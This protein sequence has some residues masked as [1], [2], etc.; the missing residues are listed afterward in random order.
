MSIYN[1]SLRGT[2]TQAECQDVPRCAKCL[3]GGKKGKLT[4]NQQFL[5]PAICHCKSEPMAM[6]GYAWLCM[7]YPASRFFW[8]WQA[9]QNSPGIRGFRAVISGFFAI[10]KPANWRHVED[11]TQPQNR[12]LIRPTINMVRKGGLAPMV[13]P[14]YSCPDTSDRGLDSPSTRHA[15]PEA[16]PDSWKND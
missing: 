2:P 9:P 6:H 16:L 13:S 15:L 4:H 14:Y 5:G 8:R 7:A 12:W 3:E 11:W 10:S 1:I